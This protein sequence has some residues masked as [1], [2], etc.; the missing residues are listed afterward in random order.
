MVAVLGSLGRSP[1][2]RVDVL[3]LIRMLPALFGGGDRE[4]VASRFQREATRCDVPIWQYSYR[5]PITAMRL[6]EMGVIY[7]Q[8][9]YYARPG[10]E[11]LPSVSYALPE[12]AIG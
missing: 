8:G 5:C 9:Y 1:L 12:P 3:V 7:Q 2:M 11:H 10:F 4:R 6:R